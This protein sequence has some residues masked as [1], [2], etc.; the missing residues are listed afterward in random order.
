[1]SAVLHGLAVGTVVGFTIVILVVALFTVS[2]MLY[3]WWTPEALERT[4]FRIADFAVP[5]QGFSLLLPARDEAEVLPRTLDGL[6]A[7]D[8]GRFEVLVIVRDD[9]PPTKAVAERYAAR[10]GDRVRV[11][12]DRHARPSKPAALNSAFPHCRYPLIGVF[13]A[14]DRV[15]PDLLLHVNAYFHQTRAD[16][17][18]GGVQL[19]D[20]ARTS[21]WRI[22]NSLEYRFWFKSRLHFQAA[23]NFTPLGGNTV[24]VRRQFLERLRFWSEELQAYC[25]WDPACL[26]EDCDLGVRASV[27]GGRIVVAYDA[28]LVTKEQTPPDLR[29]WFKQRCRWIQGFVQVL[30]KGEWRRLPSW[31]QRAIAVSTL[32]MPF[33]QAMTGVMLPVSI[34]SV[35]LLKAH[36]ALVLL[37]WLPLIPTFLTVA[38]ESQGLRELSREYDHAASPLDHLR[39]FVGAFPYQVLLAAAAVRAVARELRGIN[40]WEKTQHVEREERPVAT[41]AAA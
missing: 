40:T 23:R 29:A 26:A 1:M 27:R 15:A 7:Q 32:A 20:F 18:Q 36:V 16:I 41:E 35:V 39:L 9:D 31:R 38:V 12:V 17:V 28:A 25:Y 10:H 33:L 8:Y 21:W 3:A 34:L 5:R 19:M 11:V 37:T 13:D 14:E 2:W 22:R 6:L 4:T 24:F 30:R